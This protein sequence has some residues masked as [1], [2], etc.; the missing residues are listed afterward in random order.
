[1][2]VTAGPTVEPIDPVRFVSNHSSGKMG[3]ALARAAQQRGASVTLVSGPVALECPEGV[4]LSAV[5]SAEDMLSACEGPFAAADIAVFAAAVADYR[6]EHAAPHKLKKGRADA[7]LECIRLVPNPDILAT[8]AARKAPG[9]TV[10]G[11]AAETEDV[12]ANA[13][14]KLARKGADMIVANQVGEGLAFGT[15]TDKACLVTPSSVEELPE[16]TKDDLAHAILD[17]VV[18][19]RA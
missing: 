14:E 12:V 8:L 16:M 19:L 3:Y 17:A 11:F 10:V 13:R 1:M 9:Q 2:L 5:R 18:A 6:P 4:A 15:D 7:D